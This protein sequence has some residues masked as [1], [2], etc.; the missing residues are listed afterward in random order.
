[1]EHILQIVLGV[2][3]FSLLHIFLGYNQV[4]VAQPHRLKTTFHTKWVTF[5]F[6][7]M[8]FGLVNAGA[9]FHCTFDIAFHGLIGQSVLVYLDDVRIFSGQWSDHL[10]HLKKIFE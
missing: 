8:S 7:R 10:H 5:S 9:N 1:M 2:E 6:Q 3:M 4:F